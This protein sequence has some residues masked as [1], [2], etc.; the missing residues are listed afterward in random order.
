LRQN[1]YISLPNNVI[2]KNKA[3]NDVK[4]ESGLKLLLYPQQNEVKPS[5]NRFRYLRN[6]SRTEF[7]FL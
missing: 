2:L 4:E 1:A 3:N 6:I 5:Y 7:W